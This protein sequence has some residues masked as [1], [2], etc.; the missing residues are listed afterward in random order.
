MFPSH[1]RSSSNDGHGLFVDGPDSNAGHCTQLD[2]SSNGKWGVYNS[3]FLGNTYLA[4]H[5]ATNGSEETVTNITQANP[6]VVTTSTTHG[7]AT[8]DE[9]YLENIVGMTEANDAFYTITVLTT[10]TFSIATDTSG[11]TAYSSGGNAYK[12]GA[13][14]DDDANSRNVFVGCYA[15][16]DNRPSHLIAPSV[17]IGGLHSAGF[18]NAGS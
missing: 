13:Y 11:Y 10:T 9:I 5:V 4:C 14:R 6:G 8:G 15:E 12:G 16:T 1:D 17:V 3:S 18:C 7:W 2:C